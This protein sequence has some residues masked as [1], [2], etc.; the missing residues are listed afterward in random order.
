ML[1]DDRGREL[2]GLK[3]ARLDRMKISKWPRS[4]FI[5]PRCSYNIREWILEV[6]AWTATD[7]PFYHTV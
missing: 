7:H 4:I 6:V 2:E 1:G 5:C 3:R